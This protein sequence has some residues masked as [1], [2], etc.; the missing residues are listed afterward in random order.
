M[1]EII[2]TG[3]NDNAPEQTATSEES[4]T[5]N[6]GTEYMVRELYKRVPE[7]LLSKFQIIPSRVRNLDETK[8]PIL[9]LHD[10]P[11]DPESARLNEPWFV[12]RF[13][14]L[15]CVSN[16]QMSRYN[17]VKGLPY[18]KTLV[19]DNAIEPL[20]IGPK[21]SSEIRMVYHTTPHRGLEI[22]VPVFENLSQQFPNLRLDVFSSFNAYGWPE[23]DEPYKPLFKRCEEHPQIHYHGYQPNDVVREYVSKAHYFTYPS[24]W[25]ETSCIALMEAMSAGCVCVHPNLGALPETAGGFTKMYQYNENMNEHARVFHSCMYALLE[26]KEHE[27]EHYQNLLPELAN[28]RFSWDKRAKQWESVLTYLAAVSERERNETESKSL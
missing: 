6:G 2:L 8:I 15:V 14:L 10:L 28:Y 25:L 5:A 9:W 1:V 16:W 12:D 23:R 11:E 21:S 20:Q 7:S 17:L 19:M 27:K 18:S 26:N 13:K 22:L 3:G 4:K 24:I